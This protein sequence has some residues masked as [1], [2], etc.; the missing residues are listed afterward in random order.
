[1][2]T[3]YKIIST[4]PKPSSQGPPDKKANGMFGATAMGHI[5]DC[6]FWPFW[7]N[8]GQT[9]LVTPNLMVL[10]EGSMHGV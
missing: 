9:T 7:A 3:A 2:E 6:L 5:F 4:F 10:P 1:M 8:S